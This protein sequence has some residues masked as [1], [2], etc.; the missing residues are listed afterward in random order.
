MTKAINDVEQRW[1]LVAGTGR[2]SGLLPS[3]CFLAD[4]MGRAFARKGYGLVV[5]GWPGVDHIVA[6]A[7]A[8]SLRGRGALSDHLIRILNPRR[9]IRYPEGADYPDYKGGYAVKVS[10]STQTWI[11]ALKYSDAV[12]LLGGEGATLETFHHATQEQRPSFPVETTEGD[13]A[14][15][16]KKCIEDW[17]TLPLEGISKSEFTRVLQ[18]RC[19]TVEEARLLVAGVLDLLADRFAYESAGMPRERAV[20]VSYAHEEAHWRK[21]LQNVL[22]PLER[23]VDISLWT[24]HFMK[25]G[26]E[27][28]RTIS[29]AID[30]ARVAVLLV[31][32]AFLNSQFIATEELPRI[33]SRAQRGKLRI[34]CIPM[35]EVASNALRN[36]GMPSAVEL[37]SFLAPIDV[38]RA[39]SSLPFSEQQ[40]S[41]VK[42]RL[43]VARAL[44]ETSR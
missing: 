34:L 16:F 2:R 38:T 20:F 8:E 42:V 6:R 11:E 19:A 31:S 3:I 15:A 4:E 41:L 28:V 44:D 13:A 12:V 30:E 22:R 32:A 9:P 39:L 33:I 26:E 27:F 23:S 37:A 5:G 1:V 10:D 25:P 43:A 21:R 14:R 35:D 18:Q 17:D 7:F 29:E 40:E 24:D 36:G